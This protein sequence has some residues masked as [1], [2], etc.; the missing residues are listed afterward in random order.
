MDAPEFIDKVLTPLGV[1]LGAFIAT[2]ISPQLRQ[3]SN[4][5]VALQIAAAVL[6][7]GSLKWANV[8]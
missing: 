1:G 3:Q 6:L 8:I 4:T 5:I 2:R 7:F